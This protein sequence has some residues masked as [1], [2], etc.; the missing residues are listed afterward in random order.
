MSRYLRGSS[1]P[2]SRSKWVLS[3][4]GRCSRG[5]PPH[6]MPPPPPPARIENIA[7]ERQQPSSRVERSRSPAPSQPLGSEGAY[8]SPSAPPTPTRQLDTM[9]LQEQVQ[10]LHTQLQEVKNQL[11]AFQHHLRTLE[12]AQLTH[13]RVALSLQQKEYQLELAR[14]Q[15]QQKQLQL[16]QQPQRCIGWQIVYHPVFANTQVVTSVGQTK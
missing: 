4:H 13:A 12:E 7:G 3:P 8:I 9:Q 14:Q 6:R 2:R 15:Q 10:S 11:A 1:S 5:D 16:H